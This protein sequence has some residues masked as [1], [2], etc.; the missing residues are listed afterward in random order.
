MSLYKRGNVYWVHLTVAGG[1]TIRESAQTDNRAQAQE[2]HDRRLAELW[3]A[4]RLGERPRVAFAQAA[5]D[6]LE[7]HAQ[8]KKTFEGDKVRLATMLPLLP[9]W[10]DELTTGR[11]TLIRDKL[12]EQRDLSAS[13][14]NKYLSILSGIWRYAYERERVEAVPFI[15]S[16]KGRMHRAKRRFQALTFEQAARLLAELPDHLAAM[17]RFALATGLRD[18]NV[19]LLRWENV[20]LGR[21]FVLVHGEEAKAGEDIVVPLSDDAV[22]ALQPQLGK[23]AVYV[24]TFAVFDKH[25]KELRRNPITKRSNNTAWRKARERVGLP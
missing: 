1:P 2:Y 13:T 8:G 3:R 5:A 25:G 17:A 23:H 24:F 11:M 16:F 10:L 12:R 6:W 18:A 20:D 9:A 21:R 22:E 4:R 14:C 19:R 7:G 15:P